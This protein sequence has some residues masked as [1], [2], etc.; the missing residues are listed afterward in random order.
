MTT[1][2]CTRHP[3]RPGERF[4]EI[5]EGTFCRFCTTRPSGT[6]SIQLCPTCEAD[7]RLV[8]ARQSGTVGDLADELRS[9]F[10]YPVANGGWMT[11]L[12]GAIFGA[13][14]MF[15]L[16]FGIFM[17]VLVVPLFFAVVG[18]FWTWLLRVVSATAEGEDTLPEWPE[19][20]GTRDSALGAIVM[21]TL[22][23][24]CG[25][26]AVAVWYA[27]IHSR[28]ALLAAVLFGCTY[29]PMGMLALAMTPRFAALNPLII[30]PS[31]FKVGRGYLLAIAALV[32]VMVVRLVVQKVL[33]AFPAVGALLVTTAS[34]YFLVVQARVVGLLYRVYEDDLG[35]F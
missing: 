25:L 9:A 4:C 22:V 24:M 30:I 14:T 35:W 31:I 13:I 34:L 18:Y 3:D 15:V 2:P 6:K 29:F 7:G 26:P 23:A 17:L 19:Y 5:C 28:P 32:A 12:V 10:R 20:R 11:L 8:W 21:L 1:D 33:G 16:R 27:G